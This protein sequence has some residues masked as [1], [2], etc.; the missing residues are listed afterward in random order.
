MSLMTCIAL[1][2]W[3]R[4]WNYW[5]KLWENS[6]GWEEGCWTDI[7]DLLQLHAWKPW[8][9]F[10]LLLPLGLSAPS[11]TN[12]FQSEQPR[13][14][15][16]QMR[17]TSTSPTPSSLQYSAS[18]PLPASNQPLSLPSSFTQPSEGHVNMPGNLP[19]PLLPLSSTSAHG[20][21]DQ[22]QNPFLWRLAWAVLHVAWM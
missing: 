17:P 16:N 4:S 10:S 15:L 11:V 6:C 22:S 13:L 9:C 1:F 5:V 19:Q 14:T 2:F 3:S 20:Q 12:P 21:P 8:W 7:F 18:L